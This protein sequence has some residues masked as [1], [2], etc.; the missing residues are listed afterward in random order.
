MMFNDKKVSESTIKSY[1][2]S[3]ISVLR[4]ISRC[5]VN[6]AIMSSNLRS[7]LFNTASQQ[8]TM[9]MITWTKSYSLTSELLYCPV[10][11][12]CRTTVSEEL[13]VNKSN[14]RYRKEPNKLW[15]GVQYVEQV[16]FASMF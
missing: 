12:A 4:I 1:L 13:N 15:S 5:T 11:R 7:I 14:T 6:S 8:L 10:V 3:E 16:I 9:I 2:K